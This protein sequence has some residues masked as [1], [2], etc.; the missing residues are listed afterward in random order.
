MVTDQQVRR[1]FRLSNTEKTQEIAAS[2]AGSIIVELNI[3]SFRLEQAKSNVQSLGSEPI[4]PPA[5]ST[6]SPEAR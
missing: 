2:K 1:L 5:A 6:D 3:P 4:Q